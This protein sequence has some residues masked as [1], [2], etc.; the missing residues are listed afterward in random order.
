M[1]LEFCLKKPVAR[2]KVICFVFLAVPCVKN[3][4]R[5]TE[6]NPKNPKNRKEIHFLRFLWNSG[7][8][9]MNMYQMSAAGLNMDDIQACSLSHFF[10]SQNTFL[11]KEYEFALNHNFIVKLHVLVFLHPLNKSVK[12]KVRIVRSGSGFMASWR[13]TLALS[14]MSCN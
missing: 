4:S 7:G 8:F 3:K 11:R 9:I 10:Q 14:S 6:K 13:I 1:K 12:Y 5:K 2:S